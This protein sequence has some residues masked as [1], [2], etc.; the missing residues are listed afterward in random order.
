MGPKDPD[1]FDFLLVNNSTD[2]MRLA[3][4]SSQVSGTLY[5][6]CGRSY[7]Q[8]GYLFSPAV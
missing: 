5:F 7:S 3:L 6:F 2:V 8:F 1:G 4:D